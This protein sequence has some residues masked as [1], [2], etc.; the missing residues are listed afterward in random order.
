MRGADKMAQE[1]KAFAIKPDNLSPVP[2]TY[3][4]MS[5][6]PSIL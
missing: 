5:E 6:L 4:G 3:G 2:G 1:V